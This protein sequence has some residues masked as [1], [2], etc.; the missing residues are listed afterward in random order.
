MWLAELSMEWDTYI[1]TQ[2]TKGRR[3]AVSGKWDE[4]HVKAKTCRHAGVESEG[5]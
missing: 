2:A 4:V 1:N 3:S 5:E